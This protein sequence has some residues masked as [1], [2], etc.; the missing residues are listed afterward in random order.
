M[1]ERARASLRPVKNEQFST[2]L[3]AEIG[4]RIDALVAAARARESE[5]QAAGTRAPERPINRGGILQMLIHRALPLLEDEYQVASPEKK[6]GA[7]S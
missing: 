7:R 4:A 1:H 3:P 5:A 2:R 6:R